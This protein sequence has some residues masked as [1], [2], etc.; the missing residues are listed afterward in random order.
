MEQGVVRGADG[1]AQ[2]RPSRPAGVGFGKADGYLQEVLQIHD[3]LLRLFPDLRFGGERDDGERLD[4]LAL[5]F[6][7]QATYQLYPRQGVGEALG[8]AAVI[9]S[10]VY[11]EK[12]VAV[13]VHFRIHRQH[14]ERGICTLL[15]Q[16]GFHGAPRPFQN[17]L[18]HRS[19]T[20]P[21]V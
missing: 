17:P 3:A 16:E 11:Q 14:A 8:V 21:M 12:L 9:L 4:V 13:A 5:E 18:F 20:C 2:I 7:P 15:V 10:E 19:V 1:T 6:G